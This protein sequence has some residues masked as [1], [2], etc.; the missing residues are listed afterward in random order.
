MSLSFVSFVC[1]CWFEPQSHYHLYYLC[2]GAGSNLNVIIICIIC[3]QV[4]VRVP[5]LAYDGLGL[6]FAG[7]FDID[8][9]EGG[10]GG[11]KPSRYT[12]TLAYV[13]DLIRKLD[14]EMEVR[15]RKRE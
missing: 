15:E 7:D 1:R 5:P 4:I 2:V 14:V 6:G 13:T 11:A 3:L 10:G 9:A 12:H 8:G